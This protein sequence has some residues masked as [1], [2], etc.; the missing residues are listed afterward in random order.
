MSLGLACFGVARS[1]KKFHLESNKSFQKRATTAIYDSGS[2]YY[3][4][5]ANSRA[6]KR[7]LATSLQNRLSR[8]RKAIQ[9]NVR[10]EW[11]IKI[12]TR[13]FI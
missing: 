4:T 6:L 7:F 10:V 2:K 12:T 3:L 13:D 9:L 8:F 1:E 11:E 5:R